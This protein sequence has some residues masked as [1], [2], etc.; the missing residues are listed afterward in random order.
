MVPSSLIRLLGT[1]KFSECKFV[2]GEM[3]HDFVAGPPMP[4]AADGPPANKTLAKKGADAVSDVGTGIRLL[5]KFTADIVRAILEEP[6]RFILR[7]APGSDQSRARGLAAAVRQIADQKSTDAFLVGIVADI[8][9][10]RRET[11]E[12]ANS[13][14]AKLDNLKR[15]EFKSTSK[16]LVN[17][18]YM[19]DV[20]RLEKKLGKKVGGNTV[21]ELRESIIEAVADAG[22]LSAS[23]EAKTADLSKVIAKARQNLEGVD[24]AKLQSK[25][26]QGISRAYA[27][28]APQPTS[29]ATK[30]CIVRCSGF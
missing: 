19:A 10:N 21:Q 20:L 25:L 22:S 17:R 13:I 26:S 16:T 6:F 3:S 12:L 8:V 23:D 2:Y 29:A 28:A 11:F 24:L 5:L 1:I 7:L 27:A 14:V 4:T 30:K 18:S 9:A 15:V